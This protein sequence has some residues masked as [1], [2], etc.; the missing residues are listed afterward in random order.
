MPS[1]DNC[2]N[3]FYLIIKKITFANVK[4]QENANLVSAKFYTIFS[5]QPVEQERRVTNEF[6]QILKQSS[7][8]V[9]ESDRINMKKMMSIYLW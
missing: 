7:L 4:C 5:V 8:V 2:Y 3:F 9:Q 6:S 1:P